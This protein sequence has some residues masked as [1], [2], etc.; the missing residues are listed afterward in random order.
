MY[1]EAAAMD[2]R[3]PEELLGALDP[4]QQE[5]AL[6]VAGPLCVRAGAG[7]GKTR[8]ITY[9]IAYGAAKGEID[10][11]SVLAVT[12]TSRAAAEMATRLRALGARGVQAKTFHSAALRQLIHFWE[13][14]YGGDRPGLTK[15]K[16]SLIASAVGRLGLHADKMLIRDLAAEVE[17][18]K[19]SMIDAER[20]SERAPLLGRTPPGEFGHDEFARVFEAYEQAKDQRGVIDFEDILLLTCAMLDSREDIAAAIRARYRSFV[21]DEYQDVSP[22]QQR[23]LDLWLG[24][25]KDICVVGDVAQTIYSFTGA[26]ATYLESFPKRMNGAK[27]VELV[28]DYRST[29]QVVAVANQIVAASR[30]LD[31]RSK[32][33]GLSGSV[34]LV[35][36]RESG[37]AVQFSTYEH[38][39]QEAAQVVQKIREARAAGIPLK[40]IAVLYRTNVQSRLFEQALSEQNIPF[41]LHGGARFFEREEVKRALMMLRQQARAIKLAG[42]SADSMDLAEQVEGIVSSL[43][44]TSEAPVTEGAVRDRWS[45][46]DAL[47]QMALVRTHLSLEEFVWELQERSESKAAPEVEGVTLSTLH[48]AKGLEWECVFLVGV[49]EGLLPISLAA[50]AEAVEEERRLLYVGVTRARSRLHVS[51]AAARAAG[52]A[53]TRKMSRFLAPFWPSESQVTQTRRLA[54]GTRKKA[55]ERLFAQNADSATTELYEQLRTWRRDTALEL[56]RAP[57]Q[58]LSNATLRDISSAKPRTLKQLAV[59]RGIG[60]VKLDQF[61]SDILKVIRSVSTSDG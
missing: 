15:N 35:A 31:G 4:Q 48:A 29:P 45:N 39:E 19:V 53:K 10:P 50:T 44:W 52:R 26:S 22:V 21:V 42:A 20:Y 34:R 13:R 25:R 12:F 16:A 49:S 28:R 6:Q 32:A 14:A 18:A 57:Y 55:E 1:S 2:S 7:T 37:P 3:S 8:A 9:R 54:T 33:K 17:W 5:V 51:W 43:G 47:V 56:S 41:Q 23:L 30:G 46:L 59:L 60:E 24:G 11:T 27:V 36:Q 61:G 58:V 40:Q 38:D